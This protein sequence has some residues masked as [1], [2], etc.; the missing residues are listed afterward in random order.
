MDEEHGNS[1]WVIWFE[2]K[3]PGAAGFHEPNGLPHSHRCRL[4]TEALIIE[5]ENVSDLHVNF[6]E[7]TAPQIK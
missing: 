5:R 2:E 7:G 4:L 3:Y 6:A 1:C